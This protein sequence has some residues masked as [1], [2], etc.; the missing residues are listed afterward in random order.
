M[1]GFCSTLFAATPYPRMGICYLKT[2]SANSINLIPL[3][4]SDRFQASAILTN[5]MSGFFDY[6]EYKTSTFQL[7]VTTTEEIIPSFTLIE[8]LTYYGAQTK[9]DQQLP[10]QAVN[11]EKL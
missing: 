3:S 7:R 10:L 6:D 8:P 11:I 4:P 5:Q 9:R 2:D 1:A